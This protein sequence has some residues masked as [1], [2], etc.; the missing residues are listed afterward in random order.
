LK[1]A[2]TDFTAVIGT[3]ECP[4]VSEEF[5]QS[6]K[7]QITFKAQ[8]TFAHKMINAHM[9]KNKLVNTYSSD[10]LSM[11]L[12]E[13]LYMH[14]K[15]SN[16]TFFVPCIVIQLCNVTQQMHTFQINVLIQFL[17]SFACF[18]HHVFIMRKTICTCSFERYVF[19]TFM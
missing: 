9:F 11:W 14:D 5:L 1:D 16:F 7:W 17:V 18:E 2:S 4:N 10:W 12:T 19:N 13:F 8:K 3:Y 15:D 6:G